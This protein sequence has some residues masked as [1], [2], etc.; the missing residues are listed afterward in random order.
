MPHHQPHPLPQSHNWEAP[1]PS[2]AS[3]ADA[4]CWPSTSG[5]AYH[6][7]GYSDAPF[8]SPPQQHLDYHPVDRRAVLLASLA[9]L[10][11][12]GRASADGEQQQGAAAPPPPPAEA[13]PGPTR[14]ESPP[15]LQALKQQPPPPSSSSQQPPSAAASASSTE[16]S[17]DFASDVPSNL[18]VKEYWR[19]IIQNRPPAWQS[20]ALTL[21]ESKVGAV[22]GV[23]GR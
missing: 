21:R 23:G 6:Q 12:A 14:D 8:L 10:S 1:A 2:S 19:L 5:S 11:L 17:Q 20:I 7:Y 13:A 18:R 15:L 4:G 3:S 9:T 22:G 16:F